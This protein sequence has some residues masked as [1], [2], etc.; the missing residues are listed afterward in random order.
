MTAT[1]ETVR[2]QGFMPLESDIPAGVTLA[3]WR[4]RSR[5]APVSRRP[6]LRRLRARRPVAG[7]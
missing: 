5:P 2:S 4:S 1:T 6:L 3:E 7:A